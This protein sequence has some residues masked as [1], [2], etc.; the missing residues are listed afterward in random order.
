MRADGAGETEQLLDDAL[1]ELAR[2]EI[3]PDVFVPP[4]NRFDARQFEAL[5]RRFA[6]VCG[7]PESIGLMGFQRTPQW[8]GETVYLPSYAPV[9]GRAARVLAR[10]RAL[11]S[12]ARV[13]AV[14]AG[15]AALGLGD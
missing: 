15:G 13:G 5:A 3:R 2:H 7:G 1:A 10:G 12:S 11:R 14:G 8:R 6:V 9:Y 4:Y